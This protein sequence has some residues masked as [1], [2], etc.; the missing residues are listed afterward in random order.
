VKYRILA[1][2]RKRYERLTGME[3]LA[4]FVLLG[5]LLLV[6]LGWTVD[7]GQWWDVKSF[8]VNIASISRQHS[9]AGYAVC[10]WQFWCFTESRQHKQNVHNGQQQNGSSILG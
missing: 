4:G 3:L 6:I 8:R 10:H 7:L 2:L 5:G 9:S 1:T